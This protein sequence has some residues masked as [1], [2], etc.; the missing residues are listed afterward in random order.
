MPLLCVSLDHNSGHIS[1]N[2]QCTVKPLLYHVGKM[3][4]CTRKP[5]WS[6]WKWNECMHMG[7]IQDTERLVHKE[8]S[9]GFLPS[10]IPFN[11]FARTS[12]VAHDP[13]CFKILQSNLH[14][15]CRPL[16][17][18]LVRSKNEYTW[19]MS[20]ALLQLPLRVLQQPTSQPRRVKPAAPSSFSPAAGNGSA[21]GRRERALGRHLEAPRGSYS[22]LGATRW[23]KNVS[24]FFVK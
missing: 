6:R 1:I 23:N 5:P 13:C 16:K 19:I 10:T 14:S 18:L 9:H 21:T 2:K 12:S 8:W 4:D 7:T 3:K 22:E 17:F 15:S 11:S 20:D 24:T